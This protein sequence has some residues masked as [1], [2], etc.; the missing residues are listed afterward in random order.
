[1]LRENEGK[2]EHCMM[3]T[4]QRGVTYWEGTGAYTKEGVRVLSLCLIKFE[5]EQL[6]HTVRSIDAHAFITV[7][8]GVRIYGNFP[9]KVG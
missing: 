9:K 6:L 4:R 5:I 2:M 3:E 8:E 7:Q 1:M